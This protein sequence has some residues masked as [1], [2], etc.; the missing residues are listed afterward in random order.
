MTTLITGGAGFIGGH[1]LLA[2][3][4]RGETP[5]VLDDLS[6]GRRETVP[7]NVPFIFG[8]VGDAELVSRLIRHYRVDAIL[9]FA[10]KIVVSD[11]VADP[12]NYYLSNV[13]K[14]HALLQVAV[15]ENV[16]HFVFSSS[17]AIYGN[18]SSTPVD[19]TA[20]PA[21]LSPYGR[22]KLISEYMLN[23]ASAASRLRH[24]I[25]RYYTGAGADPFGRLGQSTPEATHLIKVALDTALGRRRHMDIYGSD[26]PTSDG[27]CV[28]D[29]IHVSDLARAHLVAL[30]YLRDG[31]ES[32]ILNC[33]YGRGYSVREVVDTVK[34]TTSVDFQT[35]LASRRAGDPVSIVAD[36]DQLTGL[37]W[38]PRFDDLSTMIEHA[39]DW[40]KRLA[41]SSMNAGGRSPVSVGI[42]D[43]SGVA[44]TAL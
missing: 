9:H 31:G 15:K 4:D 26:Y 11:S 13:V 36:S 44:L 20:I 1:T 22:S 43:G 14:T 39:W 5:M 42:V 29:Y 27:T 30:D 25:L 8:D 33:G 7:P 35:R 19:E 12:L 3:L 6:T 38:T 32:R 28:R 21:P 17:A 40:E 24:V 37:G 10:A 16:K 18:P 23:D 41:T 2:L 34:R